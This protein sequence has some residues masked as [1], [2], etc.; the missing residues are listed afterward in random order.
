MSTG[1]DGSDD[2]D[3]DGQVFATDTLPGRLATVKNDSDDDGRTS[4]SSQQVQHIAVV[5]VMMTYQLLTVASAFSV[6]ASIHE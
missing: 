6:L 5:R 1:K 2:G 3:D 4:V